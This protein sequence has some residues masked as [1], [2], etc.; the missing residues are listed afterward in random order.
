VLARSIALSAGQDF[1]VKATVEHNGAF[2]Y[3]T[4]IDDMTA[5]QLV[6]TVFLDGM[7][8]RDIL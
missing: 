3:D 4:D 7:H 8:I 1:F 5:G 2:A 6:N